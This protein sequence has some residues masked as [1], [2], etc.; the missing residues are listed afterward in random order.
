MNTLFISIYRNKGAYKAQY[1]V[2]IY[3]NI[4][5]S[6]VSAMEGVHHFVPAFYPHRQSGFAWPLIPT[7]KATVVWSDSLLFRPRIGRNRLTPVFQFPHE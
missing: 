2:A 5:R 7:E 3:R 6:R 4:V 1:N